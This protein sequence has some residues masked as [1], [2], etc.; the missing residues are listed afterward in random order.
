MKHRNRFSS[1]LSEPR[2]PK[3]KSQW[4]G[5][6]VNTTRASV[7]LGL[8]ATALC[9]GQVQVDFLWVLQNSGS[10]PYAVP[11][12]AKQEMVHQLAATNI[13]WRMAVIYTDS[14]RP[15]LAGTCPGAPGPGRG[16]ICPF[17][18]DTTLFWN[19][20]ANAAY[21]NPGS[22]GSST[23]RGFASARV[24]IDTFLSGTGCLP[25]GSC[26][27]RPSA[28][29]VVIFLT[30]TGDQTFTPPPGQPDTSVTSWVNYFSDYDTSTPGPQSAQVHGFLCP[31][32][33]WTSG[34]CGDP[35]T[36]PDLYARYKELIRR[37]NGVEGSIREQDFPE[38]PQRITEILNTIV[39]EAENENHI[40]LT[41]ELQQNYPNP[42]NPST[43]IRFS[44]PNSEFATLR[45]FNLLGQEIAMLVAGHLTAGTHQVVWNP[46]STPSG[47]YF[48]RLQAGTFNQARK[49]IVLK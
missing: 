8:V 37:L 46:E 1:S 31:E 4:T 29:L 6:F 17:T 7:L 27:L 43:A 28:Q 39:A 5:G 14:D 26:S 42:F 32:S 45:I 13:D 38:V 19:G 18:T 47:I 33:T 20:S 15:Q 25:G 48:Y 11:E 23:E 49:L 40:P 3:S 10:R 36:N 34:F 41:F 2:A 9:Q 16:V 12:F 44:L 24:A 30:T 22:C 21:M 35:L